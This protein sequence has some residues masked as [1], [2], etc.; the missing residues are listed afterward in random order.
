MITLMILFFNF[1][2]ELHPWQQFD[3]RYQCEQMVDQIN[4]SSTRLPNLA[5]YC[6]DDDFD[7]SEMQAPI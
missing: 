6:T 5:F 2:A 4:T 7:P 3:S 1:P